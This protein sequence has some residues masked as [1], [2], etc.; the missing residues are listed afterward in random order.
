MGLRGADGACGG[1]TVDNGLYSNNLR[2]LLIPPVLKHILAAQAKKKRMRAVLESLL[3]AR[4]L[5]VTLTNGPGALAPLPERFAPTGGP[6]LDAA[7]GGGLR[8]GHLSEITGAASSGRMTLGVQTMAAAAAR[9]EA[10]ALVDACDT[11]DPASAAAGGLDLTRVLWVRERGDPARALKAFS[12]ILQAGGFG[13]VVLDLAEVPPGAL[14]RFAWTTW[15]RVARII[16]GSDTAA[17]LVASAHLAR[18]AGGVT[19]AC[20]ASPAR[21]QGTSP[22]ARLFTGVQPAPRVVGARQ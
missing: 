20:A 7:L 6:D 8:R 11:F 2:P 18:S 5:D 15:M 22:R 17:L 19:I 13:L 3:R 12:L 4:K 14:G 1:A 21:W 10:V 9:G 16:E